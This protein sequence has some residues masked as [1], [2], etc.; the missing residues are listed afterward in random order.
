MKP[1]SKVSTEYDPAPTR[2]PR[3][4]PLR[5]TGPDGIPPYMYAQDGNDLYQYG[6]MARRKIGGARWLRVGPGNDMAYWGSTRGIACR[7]CG[8]RC[9]SGRL[10]SDH[11]QSGRCPAFDAENPD[12]VARQNA[13]AECLLRLLGVA[14]VSVVLG[15]DPPNRRRS[16][17]SSSNSSSSSSSNSSARRHTFG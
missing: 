8:R 16:R 3:L 12:H 5:V 1:F 6:L 4:R 15:A 13:D 2:D 10:W 9:G 11:Y 14:T 7:F 17:S